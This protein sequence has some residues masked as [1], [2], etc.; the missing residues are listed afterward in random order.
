LEPTQLES[1][2]ASMVQPLFEREKEHHFGKLEAERSARIEP[3]ADL[4]AAIDE[5][6][7]RVSA[8][9]E[10]IGILGDAE[11]GLAEQQE[12]IDNRLSELAACVQLVHSASA[13]YAMGQQ[14]TLMEDAPLHITIVGARGLRDADWLPGAGKSDPYCICELEGKPDANKLETQVINNTC[15]PSWDFQGS[16]TDYAAGDSLVFKVYDK[17]SFKKDDFLGFA[18]LSGEQFHPNGFEG[19]LT[20]QDAGKG[21][22]AALQ[23][24]VAPATETT[25]SS[26]PMDHQGQQDLE[27]SAFVPSQ[28]LVGEEAGLEVARLAGAVSEEAG[29]WREASRLHEQA[30]AEISDRVEQL[31]HGVEA[32]G[33]ES[34][35]QKAELQLLLNVKE[36]FQ[37][38]QA[39]FTRMADQQA[40]MAHTVSKLVELR[41]QVDVM[42]SERR[43]PPAQRH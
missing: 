34:Q 13:Q 26:Q 18:V 16:L 28:G 31:W 9:Q 5:M 39:D 19:E 29:L 1:L 2:M 30:T 15:D 27:T 6:S 40:G 38:A 42:W 32:I 17:D 23:V 12:S 43:A 10:S 8:C 37:E 35:A 25:L 24:R 3:V 4:H 7:E 20:L 14:A 11:R 33:I 36:E 41:D 22:S 21:I